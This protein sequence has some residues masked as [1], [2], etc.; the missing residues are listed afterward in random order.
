VC[1]PQNRTEE[2]GLDVVVSWEDCGRVSGIFVNTSQDPVTLNASDWD[3]ALESCETVL[4]LDVGSGG[5]IE[6]A[7]FDGQIRLK[8]SGIAVVTNAADP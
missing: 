3:N 2:P 5:R 8:G 4:R 1:F 7:P 6:R